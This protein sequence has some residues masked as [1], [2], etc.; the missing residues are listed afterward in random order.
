MQMQ[1]FAKDRSDLEEP[2]VYTNAAAT[3]AVTGAAV[4]S[5]HFEGSVLFVESVSAGAGTVTLSRIQTSPDGVSNWTDVASFP[6]SP[7]DPTANEL[8]IPRTMLN[9]HVRYACTVSGGTR[10]ITVRA[11][12]RRKF[13]DIAAGDQP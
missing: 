5:H 4:R 9:R 10:P 6:A 1:T 8:W 7:A 3:G 11:S 13:F 2:T 12:A